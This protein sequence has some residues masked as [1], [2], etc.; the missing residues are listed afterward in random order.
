VKGSDKVNQEQ[1]QTI[2]CYLLGELTA[3]EQEQF[4]DEYFA[5]PQLF[6]RLQEAR[7][8][9]IDAYVR[10][11]LSAAQHARFE[12]YFLA[13]PHR[14]ERVA[15]AQ[16]IK[17][18]EE[19]ATPQSSV[20]RPVETPKFSLLDWFTFRPRLILA[21]ALLLF[22][23][24]LIW[25]LRPTK[26]PAPTIVQHTPPLPSATASPA[27]SESLPAP[28]PSPSPPAYKP[29]VATI[30]LLPVLVRDNEETKLLTIPAKAEIVE[31]R[32]ET[33]ASPQRRYQIHLRTPEG[34]E[35]LRTNGRV[36]SARQTEL[37]IMFRVPAK[38][39]RPA[40]YVVHL[41]GVNA[42]GETVDLSKYYF[43]LDKK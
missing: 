37:T 5:D 15:I 33:E 25:W 11:D 32:L 28:L 38:Q 21:L 2:L 1:E 3:A 16:A 7:N 41:R 39:L 26:S 23:V 43:R 6:Q 19:P 31:L 14:R 29:V 24:G 20:S 18:I 35:I 22:V 34:R 9:L 30:K 8:D 27:A 10:G 36:V 17:Q 42:Q 40:D 4:E 12:Q 13:S